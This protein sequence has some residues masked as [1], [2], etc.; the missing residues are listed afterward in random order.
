MT[1]RTACAVAR[2]QHRLKVAGLELV[3]ACLP[4]LDLYEAAKAGKQELVSA[5]TGAAKHRPWSCAFAN[6]QKT[7]VHNV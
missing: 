3:R 7:S 2:I 4:L 1:S 5:I 6:I